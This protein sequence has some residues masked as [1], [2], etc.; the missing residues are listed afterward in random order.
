MSTANGWDTF[1]LY[2]GEVTLGFDATG[3]HTGM[4]HSYW[5][6]VP[7]SRLYPQGRKRVL[8]V[9]GI[10]GLLTESASGLSPWAASLA[11]K[12]LRADGVII[13]DEQAEIAI[14]AHTTFRDNAA[15]VGTSVH[16]LV[17][18]LIKGETVDADANPRAYKIAQ[19]VV[20][21]MAKEKIEVVDCETRVYSRIHAYCGTCD[22]NV[23][24]PDGRR[25]AIVDIKTSKA[26]RAAHAMQIA[27]YA[28]AYEEEH[29]DVVF[30]DAGV[31]LAS[32]APKIKWL[33]ESM[34]CG[35][36]EALARAH[37]AFLG[38]LAVKTSMPDIAYFGE[39][40]RRN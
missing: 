1:T 2:N 34:G 14:K 29:P 7:K 39:T 8:G 38:L 33:S 18:L 21:F 3:K 32:M 36:K 20:A 17:E 12:S 35:G 28:K 40:W 26:F 10:S 16:K 24:L 25:A 23:I 15:V 9:T 6:K 11:I 30:D 27:A 37:N 5:L 19:A 13:T 4:R 31:L 22:L